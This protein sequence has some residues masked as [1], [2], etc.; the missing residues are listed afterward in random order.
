MGAGSGRVDEKLVEGATKRGHT[1]IRSF[2]NVRTE[3]P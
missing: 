2:V 1:L 3:K